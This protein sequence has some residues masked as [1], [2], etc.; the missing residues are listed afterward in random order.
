[1]SSNP[2]NKDKRLLEL[3]EQWQTGQFTRADEQELQA[4]TDSDEFRREAVEGFW[5]LPEADHATHLAS[6][7]D[8]LRRRTGGRGLVLAYSRILTAVAAVA[9]LVLAV[10]WL[11]PSRQ[12]SAP[13]DLEAS[14]SPVE[15]QPIASNLPE[16]P[17]EDKNTTGGTLPSLDRLAKTRQD[18]PASPVPESGRVSDD[19]IFA[20]KPGIAP[21]PQKRS[22]E[23]PADVSTIQS[24]EPSES[25]GQY[26]K[27]EQ[28]EKEAAPGNAAA[29][30]EEMKDSA[31]AGK[32]KDA[33]KKRPPAALAASAPVGGWSKFQEYLRRNARLPETARQNNV[34]GSVQLRFRLDENSQTIDFQILRSLGFG[35]DEEAIRLIKSY[36]W[37]RGVNPEITLEVPFVR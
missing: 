32:S 31:S 2:Y 7:R 14:K 25:Q 34:S 29:R 27:M 18:K 1:M 10:V 28:E 19:D 5:A 24:S 9:V 21:M 37:Q 3:L 4:L 8:R 11:F 20:S 30:A 16:P 26:A 17:K 6:I 13:S 22:D 33:Q 36:A 12:Q 23:T 15:N 35:C